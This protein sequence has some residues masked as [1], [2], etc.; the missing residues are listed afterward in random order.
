M[1]LLL[2][3]SLTTQSKVI[4]QAH[5]LPRGKSRLWASVCSDQTHCFR[6]G[7]VHSSQTSAQWCVMVSVQTPQ[8]DFFLPFIFQRRISAVSLWW[9]T[10]T[11]AF[12]K[13]RS[14]FIFCY[15]LWF[16]SPGRCIRLGRQQ[17]KHV[18]DGE[19]QWVE[20]RQQS[21]TH[22]AACSPSSSPAGW[23][24][25]TGKTKVTKFVGGDKDSLIAEEKSGGETPR[26]TKA[27]THTPQQANRCSAGLQ[28]KRPPWKPKPFLL[29]LPQSLLVMIEL[30]WYDVVWYGTFLWPIH[31]LSHA[32]SQDLSHPSLLTEATKQKK[33]NKTTKQ[34]K[35]KQNQNQKP[36]HCS[37]TAKTSMCHQ[38][39][40][41]HKFKTQHHRGCYEESYLHPS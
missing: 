6:N 37:G 26:K 3:G 8:P 28:K 34:N 15:W 14:A 7:Q 31:Q 16:R 27:I 17:I 25:K 39:C 5:E 29:P 23:G 41:S 36:W 38:Y 1:I 24:E 18:Q 10:R 35:R 12:S 11:A 22:T 13:N 9:V 4:S 20:P 19:R 30:I 40:F 33:C 21:R 2:T 32:P